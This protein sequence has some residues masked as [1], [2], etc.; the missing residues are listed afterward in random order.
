MPCEPGQKIQE[1]QAGALH[2]SVIMYNTKTPVGDT[3][4]EPPLLGDMD[5]DLQE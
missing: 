2:S 3:D 4:E 1:S 5:E